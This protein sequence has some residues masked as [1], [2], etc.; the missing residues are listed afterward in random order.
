VV[1]LV[2]TRTALI[3]VVVV[4]LVLLFR[5]GLNLLQ[6]LQLVQAVALIP[7]AVQLL[8]VNLQHQV[9]QSSA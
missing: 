5:D 1:V 7:V 6:P 3:L 4:V 8:L 9:E 2:V